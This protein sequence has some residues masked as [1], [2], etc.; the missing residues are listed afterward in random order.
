MQIHLAAQTY[1]QQLSLDPFANQVKGSH[2]L[3]IAALLSPHRASKVAATLRTTHITLPCQ[4]R[5]SCDSWPKTM[6]ILQSQ[7]TRPP[8]HL[9][10]SQP[11]NA[12]PTGYHKCRIEGFILY[13]LELHLDLKNLLS[14][15]VCDATFGRINYC[16]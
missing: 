7:F 2:T 13:I 1:A 8:I 16:L 4:G 11:G 12:V 14:E 6:T 5:E 15:E 10:H 3:H 9:Q